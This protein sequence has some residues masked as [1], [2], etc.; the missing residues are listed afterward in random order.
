VSR[1]SHAF[2][3]LL[4]ALML[5][6][7]LL[8][9]AMVAL[10]TA[11]VLVRNLAGGAIGWANEVTEYALYVM[12]LL[13]TPWLLRQGRHIRL[14]LVLTLAPRHLAWRME[15]CADALGFLVCLVLIRYGAIMTYESWR[16]GSITIKNLAFPEWW[17]LAP[18]PAAFALLAAEFIFRMHRLYGGDRTRRDEATSVG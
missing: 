9:L 10:V 6:A 12:T 16:I 14:D 3:L 11:D 17:L 1:L 7:A 15:L 2:G 8:L 13:S 4:N 18:I 5:C